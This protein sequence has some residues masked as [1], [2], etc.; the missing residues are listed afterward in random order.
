MDDGYKSFYSQLAFDIRL[1]LAPSIK[2]NEVSQVCEKVIETLGLFDLLF[3][4]CCK[5]FIIQE[6]IDLV[7]QIKELGLPRNLMCFF[8]ERANGKVKQLVP[9]GGVNY[10]KTV[11]QRYRMFHRMHAKGLD[12]KF[13][14]GSND[15][16]YEDHEIV[17][18][19]RDE[20]VKDKDFDRYFDEELGMKLIM[21]IVAFLEGNCVENKLLSSFYRVWHT[22]QS[23]QSL[24]LKVRNLTFLKWIRTI[25]K[26][27]KHKQGRRKILGIFFNDIDYSYENQNEFLTKVSID[28]IYEN[29]IVPGNLNHF[30]FVP[31]GILEDIFNLNSKD[32]FYIKAI[33]KGLE[34]RGRGLFNSQYDDDIDTQTVFNTWDHKCEKSFWIKFTNKVAS[35]NNKDILS[36]T[37]F[38]KLN[39]I[40]AF[41][42]SDIL[43]NGICFANVLKVPSL[44]EKKQF[45]Y[46]I[47]K[48]DTDSCE[49]I[50]VCVNYIHST[51]IAL[52]AI[53]LN[54]YVPGSHV[55]KNNHILPIMSK[56]I[57]RRKTVIKVKDDDGETL[58]YNLRFYNG[59]IQTPDLLFLIE[60]EPQRDHSVQYESIDSDRRFE[61]INRS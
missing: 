27:H 40:M 56:L 39:Y 6:I 41:K 38:G 33:I 58:I 5:F 14:C 52:S 4:D 57:R 25:Y 8:G 36:S 44:Y 43:L 9:K 48:D 61:F 60:L 23:C 53:N 24:F 10:I 37:C 54:G 55:H 50:F 17:L 35:L 30:D 2:K 7:F 20:T 49:N 26:Y 3:P 45:H 47:L 19:K 29:F 12:K 22:Y 15:T 13:I 11:H 51:R 46:K 21:S 32:N 28:G 1:L 34:F 16:F 18:L 59:Q 42:S 31:H